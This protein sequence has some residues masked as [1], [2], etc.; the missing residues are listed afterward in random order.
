MSIG[1]I[2][3]FNK[4]T[5]ALSKIFLSKIKF[6]AP[7]PSYKITG[8]S[9]NSSSLYEDIDYEILSSMPF[10]K[11]NIPDWIKV[12]LHSINYKKNKKLIFMHIENNYNEKSFS[13]KSKKAII[14]SHENDT[15]IIKLL[16]FLIDLSVQNKCNIISYDYRGFG[17]SSSKSNDNNFLNS[18][19]YTMNYALNY[20]N[21]KIENILL[22][23]RDIGAIHSIIIASR[24]KY[25][26]CK[27]LVLIF[28]FANEKI[29][30]K[31]NMKNIICPTLLIK[32]K[33]K[34]NKEDESL[35]FFREINNEKEW[36]LKN[37]TNNIDEDILLSHRRKFINYIREYMKS[38][39]E[40]KNLY[41]LS[42]KSTNAETLLDNNEMYFDYLD[43]QND[44][45]INNKIKK[46]YMREFKEEDDNINYNNDDY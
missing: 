19:E 17:C 5:S 8:E 39:N 25:N 13:P 30:D 32:E 28:P 45:N 10:N 35:L 14:Y 2:E 27:G 23:G 31:N 3:E 40:D 33:D 18:Y 43:N 4:E 1:T 20:L 9:N 44:E 15:D 29:I 16:P 46:N 26:M 37:K 36:L 42:R 22:I 34:N 21:Y 7:K 12:S 24:H 6:S 41:A 11:Y 38:N